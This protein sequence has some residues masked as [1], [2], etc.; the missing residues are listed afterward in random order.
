[1]N[2]D[3][4]AFCCFHWIFHEALLESGLFD[5]VM[6]DDRDLITRHTL[7]FEL[8]K[9]MDDDGNLAFGNVCPFQFFRISAHMIHLFG[10]IDVLLLVE[11]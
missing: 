11:Y 9:V 1:M 8:F 7:F 10:F 2:N 6:D 4:N 3:A 5:Q